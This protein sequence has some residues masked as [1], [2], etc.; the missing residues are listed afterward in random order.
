MRIKDLKAGLLHQLYKV[1]EK[2]GTEPRVIVRALYKYFPEAKAGAIESVLKELDSNGLVDLVHGGVRL[3]SWGIEQIEDPSTEAGALVVQSITVH[4]GHVQVGDHNRQSITYASV[5]E[6]L[7]LRV[8]GAD[9]PPAQRGAAS[10]ALAI[11]LN[12]PDLNSILR[13]HVGG[14]SQGRSET[15]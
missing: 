6:E 2:S 10:D 15:E 8:E 9:L 3:T 12:Q 14:A 5:L 4:G 7:R 11:L 1:Y 13:S